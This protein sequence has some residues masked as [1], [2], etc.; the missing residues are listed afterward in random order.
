MDLSPYI[1][2]LILLNEC[3][4]LPGFGGFETQYL[5]A[6]FDEINGI[7]L[8]PTKKVVFRSDYKSGGD[9][10]S[11]HIQ[12]KLNLGPEEA[13]KLIS[14]FIA[15]IKSEIGL[16]R[17]V[18][19]N[20]IGTFSR[21]ISGAVVFVAI[22]KEN[23]LADSFG[24]GPLPV[25]NIKKKKNLIAEKPVVLNLRKRNNTLA[26][27]ITG[28]VTICLLLAATI[29]LSSRYNLFLFNI[30]NKKPANDIL[31]FGGDNGTDSL[32]LGIYEKINEST[33]IKKALQYSPETDNKKVTPGNFPSGEFYHL[34]AG[35]FKN[36]HNATVLKR[37]FEKEGFEPEIKLL[38]GLYRVCLGG[39]DNKQAALAELQRIRRQTGRSVWLLTVSSANK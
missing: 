4:I 16:G 1:R 10:L 9:I 23:F 38:G 36:R 8:P 32:S 26:V 33:S 29:I 13:N 19:L 21:N 28:L 5:P 24:L 14:D 15:G 18:V 39:F 25:K 34:I 30:G 17:E 20:G 3:I 6:R 27:I 22:E 7:M 12:K 31:I 11:G 37:S 35:S 2:E